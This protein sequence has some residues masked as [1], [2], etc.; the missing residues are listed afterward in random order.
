MKHH[1]W[2]EI[3]EGIQQHPNKQTINAFVRFKNKEAALNAAKEM[4]VHKIKV[5]F[6][7]LIV[8][9]VK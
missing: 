8:K 1:G 2:P 9:Y 3:E 5:L 4:F 7:S 6:I